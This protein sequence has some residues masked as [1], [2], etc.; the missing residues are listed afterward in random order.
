[1]VHTRLRCSSVVGVAA[2]DTAAKT[3]KHSTGR[4][5]RASAI[6]VSL[7]DVVRDVKVVTV[8][9]SLVSY[10]KYVAEVVNKFAW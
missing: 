1:M 10:P 8:E 6:A 3:V 4:Y 7:P 9:N 5:T 2:S